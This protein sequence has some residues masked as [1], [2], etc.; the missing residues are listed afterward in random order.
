MERTTDALDRKTSD[1]VQ[2]REQ[3]ERE[4]AQLVEQLDTKK[5]RLTEEQEKNM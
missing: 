1:F 5:I 4:K 2:V 3:L